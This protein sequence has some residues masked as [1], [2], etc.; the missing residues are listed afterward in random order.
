MSKK[1]NSVMTTLL[2]LPGMDGS[3]V[4]F[5]QFVAALGSAC[6]TIV[7]HYPPHNALNYSDLLG[8]A[9]SFV[10]VDQPYVI[11]GESFSGPIAVAL[12]AN[13]GPN[14]QGLILCASFVKNPLPMFGPLAPLLGLAPLFTPPSALLS[15]VLLGSFTSAA[16]RKQLAQALAPLAPEAMRARL[17]AVLAVDVSSQLRQ[18]GVPI[19]YLQARHD[20]LVPA[21]AGRLI[22]TIRPDVMLTQ[23]DGPHLLLQ[24][25]AKAGS[26]AVLDFLAK[27]NH[28]DIY[29]EHN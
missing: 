4:Q 12:A 2:L 22:K 20:R 11:L 16:L 15:P 9:H 5:A 29:S 14:L 6:K 19:M 8:I 18:V 3:G 25:Q 10:P 17:R 21:S 1:Q 23:I 13:A 28:L 26:S 27:I 24:A 7:V